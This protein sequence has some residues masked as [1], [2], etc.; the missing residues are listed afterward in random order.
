MKYKAKESYSS[1]QNVNWKPNFSSVSLPADADLVCKQN[2][3]CLRVY[4]V[5]KCAK[6]ATATAVASAAATS[7]ALT[8][9]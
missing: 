5:T 9:G 7:Q 8:I 2:K 6:Q 4:S 1:F 3:H